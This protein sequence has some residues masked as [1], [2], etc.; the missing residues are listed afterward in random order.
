[1]INRVVLTGR[2]TADPVLRSTNNGTKTTRFNVAIDRHG[3]GA[4]FPS[5]V[6]WA[7]TA[8]NICNYCHKGD[9]VGIEGRLQT[10]SYEDKNTGKKIYTTDVWVYYCEFL[11]NRK[12]RTP[13]EPTGARIPELSVKDEE[14]PF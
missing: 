7:D 13:T 11:E 3:D 4:D 12:D 8:V 1:M 6:A 5:C 2:L 10:G 9:M 14:L